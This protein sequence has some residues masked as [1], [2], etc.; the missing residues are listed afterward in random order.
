[1]KSTFEYLGC[2][3]VVETSEGSD[4][5]AEIFMHIDDVKGSVIDSMTSQTSIWV[6]IHE[7]E[8]QGFLTRSPS[9]IG[10]Y[11]QENDTPDLDLILHKTASIT[12]M[13]LPNM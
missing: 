4:T 7:Y 8:G 5:H 11:I 12:N 9:K 2:L 1:M 6:P 3:L 10:A 13:E